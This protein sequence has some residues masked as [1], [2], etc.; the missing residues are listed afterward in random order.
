VPLMVV[1]CS[2][3]SKTSDLRE[4]D[5]SWRLETSLFRDAEALQRSGIMRLQRLVMSVQTAAAAILIVVCMPF[6]CALSIRF[7][8]TVAVMRSPT[9]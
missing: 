6:I 7:W 1:T 3:R 8:L 9:C 2:W 5:K 4:T